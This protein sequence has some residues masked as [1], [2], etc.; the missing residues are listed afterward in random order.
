MTLL[1]PIGDTRKNEVEEKYV[2]IF[3]SLA[4]E[5]VILHIDVPLS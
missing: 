5:A 1:T 4:Y 2:G 3:S